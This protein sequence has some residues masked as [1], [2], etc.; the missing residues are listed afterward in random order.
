MKARTLV[1]LAILITVG[2]RAIVA[3]LAMAEVST[4]ILEK[5]VHFTATN[6]EP[7]VVQ[8]GTYSVEPANEWLRLIPEAGRETVLIQT[9]P[10][11]HDEVIDAPVALSVAAGEDQ[12]HLVL[13]LP[14]GLTL[15]AAGSYSGIR[16]RATVQPTL[17]KAAIRQAFSAKPSTQAAT[18]PSI[19]GAP[20]GIAGAEL[21]V[22]GAPPPPVLV[23][24]SPGQI[25]S[26]P[27]G[28]SFSWRP[29]SQSP[30]GASYQ[31]LV[32]KAGT[33]QTQ[34][35]AN[36]QQAVLVGQIPKNVLTNYSLP[37][38]T[39][40][41][42]FL[43][44]QVRWTVK[45][46]APDTTRPIAGPGGSPPLRCSEAGPAVF[47]IQFVAP[48]LIGPPSGQVNPRLHPALKAEGYS[49][50][51]EWLLFC[52]ARPGHTCGTAPTSRSDPS[53]YVLPIRPPFFP[54]STFVAQGN[55]TQ[56][57]GQTMHWTAA[58]CH[59]NVGC[60][61]A[62]P[63][64]VVVVPD[65][66]V[67]TLLGPDSFRWTESPLHS[68]AW[69]IPPDQASTVTHYKFCL[70]VIGPSFADCEAT[71]PPPNKFVK[72]LTQTSLQLN[73]RSEVPSGLPPYLNAWTVGACNDIGCAYSGTGKGIYI[74][75]LPERSQLQAPP[76]WVVRQSPAVQI[77]WS[78]SR[79]ATFYVPCLRALTKT[80]ENGNDIFDARIPRPTHE[81]YE[82]VPS[83]RCELRGTY[84]SGASV[85][86]H[87]QVGACN[88]VWGCIW[89]NPA[90]VTFAIPSSQGN[91]T[92]Q[93]LTCVRVS[94]GP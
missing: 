61:W 55:L 17:N 46:C 28:I 68:F 69:S 27:N 40:S 31:V 47:T 66:P 85:Q 67:P 10:A 30:A 89:S 33:N 53:A 16:S 88:P 81:T 76:N 34:E 43:G 1:S 5:A 60:V 75:P 42:D 20:P 37:N 6:G 93:R 73:L 74:S 7:V 48:R 54:A 21:Q 26:E 82:S 18:Q 87:W 71:S 72:A 9:Q 32:W 84:P 52:I 57:V 11:E 2:V 50:R 63:K 36:R 29:G 64:Q 78:T 56:F 4:V 8:P 22:L 12:H 24:P 25:F 70:L 23:S 15:D 65:P 14:G 91:Q 94:T 79:H 49:S 86:K 90:I 41:D 58:A 13:L 38:R 51:T 39:L 62:D 44:K 80:C 92:P 59:T 77:T 3:G 45:A 83:Y 19:Q 35:R